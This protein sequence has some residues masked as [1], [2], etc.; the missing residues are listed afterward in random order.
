MFMRRRSV[1]GREMGLVRSA[2]QKCTRRALLEPLIL[3]NLEHLLSKPDMSRAAIKRLQVVAAEDIGVAQPG[4]LPAL[5]SLARGWERLGAGERARRLIIAAKLCASNT[6]AS[7]FLPCW[8]VTLI[9]GVAVAP[10]RALWR[11]QG[12]LIGSLRDALTRRDLTAAGLTV[13]EVLLRVPFGG[14]A[15]LPEGAHME[16]AALAAVWAALRGASLPSQA[17]LIDACEG[18][19]GPL[20]RA[21]A[22]CRLFIYLALVAVVE[23]V[24]VEG[25]A[26][27]RVD[28]GEVAGWL[29]RAK[30]AP[31]ALPDWVM[32]RHTAQGKRMGR[33]Y[34][35]FFAEATWLARPSHVLGEAR[36]Q[37]TREA[38]LALYL[39]EEQRFGRASS[40]KYMR[41]RWRAAAAEV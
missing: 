37:A 38:A 3:L 20:S 36:E 39:A 4:L 9:K 24:A 18:C 41:S 30:A 7:R 32:D 40:T 15:A 31:F 6:D 10:Q 16:P 22:G 17:A 14:E 1:H 27:P 19:F 11:P 12:A 29:A 35:H 28:D 8:L 2:Q 23:G 21:T 5:V 25:V 13:E 33:G 26:L 34:G